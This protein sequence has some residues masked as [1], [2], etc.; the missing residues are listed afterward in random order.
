MDVYRARNKPD[1]AIELIQATSHRTNLSPVGVKSLAILAEKLGRVDVAEPIVR[2]YAA[3]PNT[4]DGLIT[5]ATF[6]SR[7]GRVKEALDLYDP[8]WTQTENPETITAAC[9]QVISIASPP[10]DP[11]QLDRVAVLD[12][13]G[14]RTQER[15]EPPAGKPW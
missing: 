9:S 14:P 5:L 4:P 2:Q 7:H 12:R 1:K 13:T 8:L 6:L 15:L 11:V 10:A 3:L